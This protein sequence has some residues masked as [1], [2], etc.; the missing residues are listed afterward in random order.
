MSVYIALL[1]GINVGRAKRVPMAELRELLAG[2]G[3]SSVRTLI[4]SGNAVFEA[5]DRPTGELAAEIEA[6]LASRF[7]FPVPVVVQTAAG[8]AAIVAE[9]PLPHAEREPSKFL[10][11][12]VP[13]PTDLHKLAPLLDESWDPDQLAVGSLAAY[14]WCVSGILE[15]RLFQ[16]VGRAMGKAVTIRNWATVLKL[17]AAASR[18][19]K[20]V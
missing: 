8:L 19:D 6:A 5:G 16:E 9:N 10:V 20:A 3:Y 12:F 15:S 18:S 17:H 4:N 7:G 2:L 14:V 1:R 13:A 11:A